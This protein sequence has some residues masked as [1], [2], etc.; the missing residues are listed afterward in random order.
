VQIGG[1]GGENGGATPAPQATPDTVNENS[2]NSNGGVFVDLIGGGGVSCA[3][4]P[5]GP[6]FIQG[7]IPQCGYTYQIGINTAGQRFGYLNNSDGIMSEFS[8][9]AQI[10][11]N[12]CQWGTSTT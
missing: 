12:T 7:G 3:G 11:V 8:L 1:G 10:D 2:C 5:N 6:H 9:G 4:E